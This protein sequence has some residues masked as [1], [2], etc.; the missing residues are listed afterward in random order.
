[1]TIELRKWQQP[2]VESMRNG[3]PEDYLL[4]A[5]PGSG[6]TLA[7]LQIA[8][9]ARNRGDVKGIF[10]ITPTTH[11]KHQWKSAAELVGLNLRT[12]VGG[13]LRGCDGVVLTFS[14]WHNSA[15]FYASLVQMN[16]GMVI[17]DEVH[18]VGEAEHSAWGETIP[19]SLESAVCRLSLSGTPFRSTGTRIPFVEYDDAGIAVPSF[20]YS[21]RQALADGYVR[22]IR[23]ELF[24]S[25]VSWF[26]DEDEITAKLS[27]ANTKATQAK[28]NRHATDPKG[29]FSGE[30]L[31]AANEQLL[32][33][34]VEYPHAGGL[35]FA[36]SVTHAKQIAGLLQEIA[37]GAVS[38]ATSSVGTSHHR[39]EKMNGSDV[40]DAFR[41]DEDAMWLVTC[42]MVSEGVDIPRLTVAVWASVVRT[43]LAFQQG[44][45]RIIRHVK[46]GPET[47]TAT[48]FVP[49]DTVME[50]F[51]RDFE[52]GLIVELD[53]EAVVPRNGAP[54]DFVGGVPTRFR[55]SDP[56]YIGTMVN[57]ELIEDLA[58]QISR[59]LG[60]TIEEA[61]NS[62]DQLT[63]VEPKDFE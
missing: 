52:D 51:C 1:M 49:R 57:G 54:R 36:N 12:K 39:G 46:D 61:R 55:A 2:L 56:E 59:S 21:Y 40:I 10:V 26:E 44:V 16:Q 5:T 43:E 45:G 8:V 6:K 11:L 30:I 15:W 50:G 17:L 31:E 32:K 37:P 53:E 22:R 24:D 27:G 28:A 58:R 13:A 23:F 60:V 4:V 3:L 62:L 41:N 47:Q 14:D 9:E 20:E 63:N 38:L 34:R 25:E 18:H 48:M 7:A 29:K 33:D 19:A 42:K 35:V